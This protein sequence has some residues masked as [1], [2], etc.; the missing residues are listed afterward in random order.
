MTNHRQQQSNVSPLGVAPEAI[1][2]VR[3]LALAALLVTAPAFGAAYAADT[4]PPAAMT[5]AV[6]PDRAAAY[7][8]FGLAHMYEE[9]ATNTG[10][11]DYATRAIEEYKLALNADPTSP[12]L[13]NGLAQLY[14]STGRVRDAILAAQDM[15]KKDPNDLEA[16]KLLG[17][18]YLRSLGETQNAE[19]QKMLDLSIAEFT[20]ITQLQPS[21]IESHLLLGQLYT[22]NHD[23]AHAR[24]QFEAA[25][26]IDPNNEDV[27]LSLARLYSDSGD[28]QRSVEVLKS[29]PAEDRTAKI[30][31]ALGVAY[32]QMHDTKNAIDSYRDAVDQEPDNPDAERALGQDLLNDAQLA[33]ALKVFQDLATASPQDEEAYVRISEIQRRQGNYQD[34]LA[35]LKKAQALASKEGLIEVDYDEALILDCLSRYDEA[36]TLLKKV[37]ADTEQPHYSEGERSNRGLF[38]DRLALIYREQNH[39]DEAIAVYQQVVALGGDFAVRGYEGE[40]DVYREAREYDKATTVAKEAAAKFPKDHSLQLMLALQLADMG[41]A[42]EAVKIEKAQQSS[43]AIGERELDENLAQIYMRLRRW[44]DASDEL[45]KAESSEPVKSSARQDDQLAVL[46]LRGSVEERQKHYDAAEVYF[47][48]ILAIDP[49]NIQTLNYYGYMLADRG[50][51]LE[52]ALRMVQKAVQLDPQNYAYL[53]S[54][55][56]TYFKLGQYTLA[57]DNLRQA[58]QRMGTDPTVHDHLGELYEKTGRLKQAAEQWEIS[59][60]EYETSMPG[61]TEPGDVNKVQKKLELARVKLAKGAPGTASN[62]E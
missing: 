36:I 13:N 62:K 20:K 22:L 39:T 51:Q 28:M 43:G 10:R 53:D 31:Y 32:D 26:K 3:Y 47:K 30:S 48:K 16:H 42:D 45:D 57:E 8:H 21:D 6:A 52:D 46:F 44:K 58:S 18:I 40:N 37:L 12:Y 33:P 54:L 19:S 2:R 35:T 15:I 7:Y 56:W 14:F 27:A 11:Q 1:K 5:P 34:A 9:M 50:V 60:T 25:E 23:S 41:K 38:L 59:L 29:V 55:G 61:D 4:T 24:E 49:N 17:R